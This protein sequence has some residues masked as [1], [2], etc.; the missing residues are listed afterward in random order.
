MPRENSF[1]DSEG[2]SLTPDLE[3]ELEAQ[4]SR[5]P[6][7]PKSPILSHKT[8]SI[9]S[10]LSQRH[11]PPRPSLAQP[12]LTPI[13]RFRMSVRKVMHITKTSSYLMG[14]GPG[15]EPG[16][17]V[18]RDSA[19][20]SYGHIRQNCQIE[21][22]DYSSVRSSFGR[23][24]NQEFINFLSSPPASEPEP[25]VKVRWINVGGISWDV[26]RA[27]ALKYGKSDL[28][29]FSSSPHPPVVAQ[30]FTH[31]RLRTSFTSPADLAPA[32]TTTKGTSSSASSATPLVN[33][34]NFNQTSSSRLPV[35]L[36]QN[37]L[38]SKTRSKAYPSARRK[39][40]VPPDLLP[41]SRANSGH[42]IKLPQ[43]SLE[44]TTSKMWTPLSPL[45]APSTA[46]S[47]AL[48]YNHKSIVRPRI[49]SHMLSRTKGKESIK[50]FSSSCKSSGKA[51]G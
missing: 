6:I 10:R 33:Q 18:R 31:C 2:R 38:R 47:M 16:V 8:K 30:N 45:S 25:W 22:V 43:W 13:E 21:I 12:T 50:P 27:L 14:K 9:K 11:M 46:P 42:P 36:L 19:Y 4:R 41:S 26:I 28:P 29:P 23:M 34:E 15:A 40:V 49:Y 39:R 32:Q 7:R 20:L 35:R 51:V 48:M 17:D 1:S 5:S 44:V 24:T 3:D 37:P